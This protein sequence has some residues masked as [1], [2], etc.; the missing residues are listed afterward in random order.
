MGGDARAGRARRAFAFRFDPLWLAD[1]AGLAA[2]AS[3]GWALTGAPGGVTLA[4][5]DTAALAREAAPL[6]LTAWAAVR[7]T[8]FA[9]SAR[10]RRGAVRADLYGRLRDL[11]TALSDLRRS[12]SRD[13]ARAFFD[14]NEAFAAAVPP[15]AGRLGGRERRLARECASI[16][17]GLA[18]RLRRVV[19]QRHG[20]EALAERIR[21]EA[22][23]AERFGELDGD[24]V[25]GLLDAMED[26]LA[27]LDEALYADLNADHFG[28]IEADSRAFLSL[29]ERVRVPSAARIEEKGLDLFDALKAQVAAKIEVAEAVEDWKRVCRPLEGRLAAADAPTV[30]P[31]P[32]AVSPRLMERFERLA[33]AAEPRRSAQIIRLP[34]AN[35]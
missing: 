23:R 18:G 2:L 30:R 13:S 3:L 35:D 24:E 20:L 12:L 5:V 21:R 28:R 31:A 34:A 1:A 6:A 7:G 14:R 9:V 15:A 25:M 16:A 29:V 4:G 19:A 8:A 11:D 32:A 33:P 17:N 27:V 22:A 10:L 26:A